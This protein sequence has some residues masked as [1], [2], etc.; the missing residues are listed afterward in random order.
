MKYLF[1]IIALFL[2]VLSG[3]RAM[4][5]PDMTSAVPVIY[6][7]TDPN[8]ARTEQIHLFHQWLEKNGYV[9][10]D[11][12]HKVEMRLDTANQGTNKLIVQGV[13]GVASDVFD[14]Y[15]GPVVRIYQTIGMVHDVTEAGLKLGFSPQSTYP[16][17]EADLTINGRQYAFPCNVNTNLYWVNGEAFEKAGMDLPPA[18]W[19]IPT[20]ERIGREFIERSNP[21]GQRQTVFFVPN[22]DRLVLARS[23]GLSSLNETLTRPMYDDPRY[24]RVY[25]LHYQW[26]YRDHLMP[27]AAERESFA[28]ASGYGGVNFQLFNAG[29]FALLDSGR[30]ALI[31]LRQFNQTRRERGQPLLKLSVS[32][33]PYDHFPNSLGSTRCAGTYLGSPNRDLAVLFLAYLASEEYNMQ[34]VRDGDAL[35]PNP[36]YAQI[37]EFTNPPKYPEEW[38]VH[39]PFNKAMWEIAIPADHGPFIVPATMNRLEN[40]HFQMFMND[41]VTAEQAGQAAVKEIVG[42]I[43]RTL[44][45]AP[46]LRPLY[47][48]A[49]ATQK[50]IEE[51]RAA[52]K[53]VPL[54]W[55]KNPFHRKYYLEKG[56]AIKDQ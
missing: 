24:N 31:Q 30:Y 18:R 16:A 34:I 2:I 45:E 15:S 40:Y 22:V 54:S 48:E 52:G 50:K 20:F 46:R 41:R 26:T 35:P 5:L 4:T 55:I 44:R 8:P 43:E 9:T 32:E 25:E 7:S 51:Y 47:D 38:G 19:D 33:L 11:G 39:E 12:Q 28:S 42:E 13:S 36:K 10:A 49:L 53:P 56:W 23:M 6:W 21:K 14:M 17:L 37:P 27:T 29:R 3:I 1:L